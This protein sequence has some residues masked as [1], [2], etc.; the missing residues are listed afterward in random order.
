MPMLV[1]AVLV[2][3]FMIVFAMPPLMVASIMLAL[4]RAFATHFFNPLGGGEPLLW[5]HVFWFFGHPDVYIIMV[6]AFGILRWSSWRPRGDRSSA[7][8]P[9]SLARRDRL[10][11]LRALGAPHVRHRAAAARHE[12]LQRGQHDDRDPER[13]PGLLLDRHRSGTDASA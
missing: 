5:Q 6:P 2:M 13:R 7:T 9:S 4:D 12:L 10:P 3:A 11:Q 8:P 1:W